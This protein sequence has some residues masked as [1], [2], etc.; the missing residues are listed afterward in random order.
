M[1]MHLP[2]GPTYMCQPSV[3]A[4]STDTR[5]VTLEGSTSSRYPGFLSM[6]CSNSAHDGMLTTRDRTPWATSFSWA[7]THSDTSL[8]VAIRITSGSPPGASART[9][10]PRSTPDAEA[11]FV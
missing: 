9:Y 5:A 4:T 7:C 10:A 8:P 1:P 2:F 3:E 11:Y 6:Y